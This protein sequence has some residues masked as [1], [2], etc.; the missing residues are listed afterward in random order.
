MSKHFNWRVIPG[1]VASTLCGCDSTVKP[2][3]DPPTSYSAADDTLP[4]GDLSD[5]NLT[6]ATD[7]AAIAEL[8]ETVKKQFAMARAVSIQQAREVTESA[9]RLADRMH[10]DTKDAEECLDEFKET[11]A[12]YKRLL[13]A[14]EANVETLEAHVLEHADDLETFLVYEIK[15]QTEDDRLYEKE[16]LAKAMQRL[17]H[18]ADVLGRVR[19]NTTSP[20][21]AEECDNLLERIPGYCKDRIQR[22]QRRLSTIG[23]P[24][25]LPAKESGIWLNGPPPEADEFTGKVVLIDFWALWCGPCIA[26]FPKVE[27]WHKKYSPE[28]LVVV[29][30]TQQED[31]GNP[32]GKPQV[33]RIQD[34]FQENQLGFQCLVEHGELQRAYHA[35]GLPHYAL[36]DRSGVIHMVRTGNNKQSIEDM[37]DEIVALLT[38]LN[39]RE[40]N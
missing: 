2:L 12:F 11:L 16:P 28:G 22:A 13:D 35:E 33:E 40:G 32:D 6:K 5:K 39:S 15:F 27:T 26:G 17:D 4:V 29:A 20:R 23:T 10:P 31:D 36:V 38:G 24:A 3:A 8:G 18:I 14:D 9:A 34:L 30:V 37:E 19:A 7:T 1:L 21:I 25:V